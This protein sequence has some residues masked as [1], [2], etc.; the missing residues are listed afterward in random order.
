[1]NDL[2]AQGLIFS[3]TRRDL[4]RNVLVLVVP[5][6]SQLSLHS[7]AELVRPEVVRVTIGNPKRFLPAST[8]RRR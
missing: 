5:A 6:D 1:M 7:F 3:E 2:Q 8:P 4:A